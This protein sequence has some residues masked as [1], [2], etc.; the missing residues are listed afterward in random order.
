M[1]GAGSVREGCYRGAQ[2]VQGCGGCDGYLSASEPV[3]NVQAV[4]SVLFLPTAFGPAIGPCA[5]ERAM[6]AA[7]GGGDKADDE[8]IQHP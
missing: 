1:C 5:V 3:W 6:L 7:L 2:E 8:A 4:V